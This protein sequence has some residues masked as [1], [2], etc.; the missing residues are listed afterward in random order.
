VKTK[1]PTEIDTAHLHQPPKGR[2]NNRVQPSYSDISRVHGHTENESDV[3]IPTAAEAATQQTRS[4]PVPSPGSQ[5]SPTQQA[6]L[7]SPLS[8][9]A[10]F[11]LAN[12][13]RKLAEIYK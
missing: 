11:G 10:M 7:T 13:K 3:K 1:I 5:E 12:T 9:G 8:E 6:G 4:R 2:E